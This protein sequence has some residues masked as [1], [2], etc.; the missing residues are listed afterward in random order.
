MDHA[1]R[2]HSALPGIERQ[3][4]TAGYL[5]L[6]PAFNDE[7]QLIRSWMPVPGILTSNHSKPETTCVHLAEDLIPVVIG[8]TC[9]FCSDIYDSQW[10]MP[11]RFVH[12]RVSRWNRRSHLM[13]HVL[14]W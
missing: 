13:P 6:E 8:Y 12:V 11:N 1:G 9:C 5:D 14:S 3:D 7:K 10:W 4:L 2:N